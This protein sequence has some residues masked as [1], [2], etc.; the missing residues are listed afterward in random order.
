MQVGGDLPAE[1]GIVF[2]DDDFWP[3]LVVL[4]DDF[5]PLFE[6]AL[7]P[8]LADHPRSPAPTEFPRPQQES[9]QGPL[10]SAASHVFFACLKAD[11]RLN[12]RQSWAI[13]RRRCRMVGADWLGS[14]GGL[15]VL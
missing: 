5:W 2:Y 11:M 14:F 8:N 9:P 12:N 4:N 7:R 13:A 3:P 6:P 10:G 1:Q 15:Q